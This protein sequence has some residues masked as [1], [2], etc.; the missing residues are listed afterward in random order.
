MDL[1]AMVFTLSFVAWI[2]SPFSRVSYLST[3]KLLDRTFTFSLAVL[4]LS[5]AEMRSFLSF[6]FSAFKT[7][8]LD[9]ADMAFTSWLRYSDVMWMVSPSA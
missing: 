1:A 9:P 3:L 2:C 7:S 4:A 8:T 6:E 5:M